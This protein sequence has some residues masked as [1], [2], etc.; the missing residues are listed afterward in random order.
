MRGN[1][2]PTSTA[3]L[4]RTERGG[5]PD[6]LTLRDEHGTRRSSG[7]EL[8]H[9]DAI[10]PPR[11]VGGSEGPGLALPGDPDRYCGMREGW[12]AA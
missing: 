5:P 1:R 6:M 11:G 10:R 7:G 12:R 2:F 3:R 4:R 9:P 8:G